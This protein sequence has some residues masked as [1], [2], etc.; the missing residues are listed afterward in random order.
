MPTIL[1]SVR[2]VLGQGRVN[3]TLTGYWYGRQDY[4]KIYR[5]Y[6]KYGT[7][8]QL[9][10]RRNLDVTKGNLQF[11]KGLK[12]NTA[13][14][15]LKLSKLIFSATQQTQY[16]TGIQYQRSNRLKCYVHKTALSLNLPPK[17]Q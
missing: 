7:V 9:L 6:Y 8:R 10:G 2:Q 3:K 17:K 13:N 14:F 1:R 11:N 5:F 16:S 15:K 4:H 12:Q